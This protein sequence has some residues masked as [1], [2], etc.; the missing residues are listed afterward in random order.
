VGNA[1]LRAEQGRNAKRVAV[2]SCPAAWGEPGSTYAR[3]DRPE[4]TR[5][6]RLPLL[7]PHLTT[8]QIDQAALTGESLPVKKFTGDVAFSG[9]TCKAGE[10]HCLVYA[11]GG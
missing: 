9:S 1:V 5:V 7:A 10:R 8:P 2:C 11:T 4:K 6:A 3:V